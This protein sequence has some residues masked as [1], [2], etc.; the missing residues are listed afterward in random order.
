MLP[1]SGGP[2]SRPRRC[3]KTS[4]VLRAHSIGQEGMTSSISPIRRMVS[5]R[6]IT[7]WL[8]Y[9]PYHPVS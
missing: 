4:E 2:Q 1:C 3:P 9:S 5:L 7:L 6:A 8:T